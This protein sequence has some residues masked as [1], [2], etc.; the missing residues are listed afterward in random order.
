MRQAQGKPK[1]IGRV[2]HYFGNIGVAAIKLSAPLAQGDS[3][4]IEGGET[5]FSQ[6]VGSM[7]VDHKP[8]ARAKK[9]DEIGLKVKKKARE[10]YRV[11][12]G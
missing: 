5:A 8:V 1:L 4:R 11:Y 10:G 6:E 2:T 3:V 7:Q 12:K 9:G